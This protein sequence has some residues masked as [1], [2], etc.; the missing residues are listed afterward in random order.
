MNGLLLSIV[1]LA[2]V[3]AGME[4]KAPGVIDQLTQAFGTIEW[5]HENQCLTRLAD[6]LAAHQ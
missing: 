6:A 4:A 2:C 1:L 3:V 5:C